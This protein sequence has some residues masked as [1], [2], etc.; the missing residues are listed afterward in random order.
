[1]NVQYVVVSVI[2]IIAGYLSGSVNYAIPVTRMVIGKDIRTIGNHNPGTSNVV[3]EVGAAWGVLV[4][5]LDGMKG[6]VPVLILRIVFFSGD[7]GIDFFILYL[8]GFAA[9]IGHCKSV[10]LKFKGGGGIGT[11][12]G[13]SLFFV[14]VEFLFSMFLGGLIVL[15]FFRNAKY[16][17]GQK[18][19]I[20][21]VTLTP[22]VTLAS[23]L[24]MDIRLFA[25]ISI[26]GH[27]WGTI[28]G[29]FVMSLGILSFNL[30]FLTSKSGKR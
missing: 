17:F 22:F 12:L 11:M 5:F 2:S 7:S 18:T 9:V 23:S 25:H 16:R 14:P 30:K 3:R 4:G 13:V 1:M 10:F 21:F 15:I 27:N 24:I 29:A 8:T 20:F 19:P 6:L 28:A 26:G